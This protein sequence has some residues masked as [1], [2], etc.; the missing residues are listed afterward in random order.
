MVEAGD[1]GVAFSEFLFGVLDG[2]FESIVFLL[3]FGY[4]V[5]FVL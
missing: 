2:V 1:D 5:R 3:E 4:E